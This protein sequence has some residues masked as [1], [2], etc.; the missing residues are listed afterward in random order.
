M[1]AC[2]IPSSYYPNFLKS[3]NLKNRRL[4]LAARPGDLI[5]S[6]DL[7]L[8]EVNIPDLQAGQF[9]IR[10]LYLSL[11]PVMKF[12][13]LDGAGIEQ[14]LQI[15]DLMRGRGVG[16]VIQSRHADFQV[17]DIVQGKCGWQEYVVCDGSPY[18]MMYKV[19]QRSL[20]YS[21]ALGVLGMTGFTSYF[22]LYEV[23]QLKAGDQVLVSAAAGGVGSNL[24]HLARIKGARAIGLASTDEKCNLLTEKLGY[25][26]AI[27]Y[28]KEDVGERIAHY[29]P[30]GIDVYFDNVGGEMLDQALLHLRRY[31]RVVCCGRIS[32]YQ[33]LHSASYALQNWHKIGATRSRMEGF[34]I[35]DFEPHF[36]KAEA[37]MAQWIKE[38]RLQYQEDVLEGLENMPNALNRLFERKNVGKQLVKIFLD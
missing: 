5:K 13:M 2:L 20:P 19:R 18:Y 4:V 8:Q 30:E 1:K 14:P 36:P 11:A 28:L 27:N 6:S 16:E 23:G 12:Y 7:A 9:L 34:F 35:Y 24:G 29:F 26:G 17:G 15:G 37:D 32:Q 10:V 31:A 25:E 3:N 22:G 33:D 38:G 21:T